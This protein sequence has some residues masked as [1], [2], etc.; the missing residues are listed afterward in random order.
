MGK[1]RIHIIFVVAG[2]LVAVGIGLWILIPHREPM[3][4]E[5]TVAFASLSNDIIAKL[6]PYFPTV[7][8]LG[9]GVE[10]VSATAQ[11]YAVGLILQE[12]HIRSSD[13][14]ESLGVQYRRYFNGG[15]GYSASVLMSTADSF[16]MT[17]TKG[18]ET[19][20]ITISR[21]GDIASIIIKRFL[22]YQAEYLK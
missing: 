13:S 2:L 1:R 8:L 7:Y 16:G 14:V 10:M 5:E 11:K 22:P 9:N 17:A 12:V 19:V 18:T 21:Q 6:P 3:A 4:S 15:I 20:S